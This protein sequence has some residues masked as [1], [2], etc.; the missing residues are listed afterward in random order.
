M[1]T[2]QFISL[3]EIENSGVMR[4]MGYPTLYN[5][6]RECLGYE[7]DEALVVLKDFI[8]AKLKFVRK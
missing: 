3:L 8:I 2:K 5:F 4:A 6:L 7:K 1:E